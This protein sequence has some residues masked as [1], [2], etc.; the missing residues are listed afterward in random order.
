MLTA[1]QREEVRKQADTH[2]DR[3][4]AFQAEIAEHEAA[5]VN[6]N[7]EIAE[8]VEKRKL[9]TEQMKSPADAYDKAH[10]DG[11]REDKARGDKARGNR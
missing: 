1:V 11:A 10:G 9:Y 8:L 2:G 7:A 3:I 4:A 5:I 6:L